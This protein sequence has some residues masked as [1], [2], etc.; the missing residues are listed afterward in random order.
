MQLA[1]RKARPP[2]P[3]EHRLDRH[4]ARAGGP[5]NHAPVR[6]DR[7]MRARHPPTA[8]HCR[9]CRRGL[10]GSAPA[11]R[12][13]AARIGRRPDSAPQS[14]HAAPPPSRKP[15]HRS[16]RRHRATRRSPTCRRHASGRRCARPS[17]ALRAIAARD[18]CRRR[19]R[20]HHPHASPQRRPRRSRAV[21]RRIPAMDWAPPDSSELSVPHPYT[22]GLRSREPQLTQSEHDAAANSNHYSSAFCTMACTNQSSGGRCTARRDRARHRRNSP[23]AR[24]SM[25]LGR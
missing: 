24:A 9:C 4:L 19:A 21:H 15:P 7:S 17:A 16:T 12:R 11:R 23:P 8:R 20:V 5:G 13:S 14:P 25:R 1:C 6:Q 10:R 3:G 18:R 22:A 2:R